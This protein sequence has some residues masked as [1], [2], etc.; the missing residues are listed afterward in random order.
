M[1][2]TFIL[3]SV[4]FRFHI[5]MIWFTIIQQIFQ[6]WCYC[7]WLNENQHSMINK[8]SKS[9]NKKCCSILYSLRLKPSLYSSIVIFFHAS[10]KWLIPVSLCQCKHKSERCTNYKVASCW[11]YEQRSCKVYPRTPTCRAF[12]QIART[13]SISVCPSLSTTWKPSIT[14]HVVA[15]LQALITLFS[16]FETFHRRVAAFFSPNLHKIHHGT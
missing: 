1:K 15:R 7:N 6:L 13:R 16:F 12:I 10:R 2:G 3:I 4:L 5:S 14:T 11:K 9:N 8:W